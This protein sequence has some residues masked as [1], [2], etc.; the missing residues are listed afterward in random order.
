VIEYGLL[1][2]YLIDEDMPLTDQ[3]VKGMY[4]RMEGKIYFLL[5]RKLKTQ[6][7]QG[8]L[9]IMKMKS[10]SSGKVL[11]RTIKAGL[12]IE[13]IIPE[14]KEVQFSYIDDNN[15]YFMDT[16]TYEL[17]PISKEVLGNY[18]NFLKEGEKI[19]IL[20]NDGEVL[21]IKENATVKLKV[22]EATD[23]VR[24]N[25]ANNATKTVQLETGYKV[26]VPLF[27]KTGD[28]LIINTETGQYTSRA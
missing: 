22:I 7:R 6:G 20:F 8:G 17:I 16:E 1:I 11:K 3:P 15:A 12:K 24:G 27:I 2:I 28:I 13:Q 21:T 19:L 18:I 10:L 26:N 5:D 25:T 9:I 14:T 4:I 23:S